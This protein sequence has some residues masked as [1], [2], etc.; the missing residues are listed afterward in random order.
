MNSN[1]L[2]NWKRVFSC[3]ETRSQD[4]EEFVLTPPEIVT[5]ES[6]YFIIRQHHSSF[7]GK[8]VHNLTDFELDC[9][10]LKFEVENCLLQ[11]A[12]KPV[13]HNYQF[14]MSESIDDVRNGLRNRK[15]KNKPTLAASVLKD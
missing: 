14:R 6:I 5:L 10:T 2:G 12:P 11:H 1:D 15:K 7:Q 8:N 9:A 13:K 4:D 3:F